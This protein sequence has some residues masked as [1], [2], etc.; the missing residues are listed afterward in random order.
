MKGLNNIY[1]DVFALQ[2]EILI[3]PHHSIHWDI[4][5]SWFF[6]P[7]FPPPSFHLQRKQRFPRVATCS[8]VAHRCVMKFHWG[9]DILITSSPHNWLLC[10]VFPMNRPSYIIRLREL[11]LFQWPV[12][13]IDT[14]QRCSCITYFTLKFSSHI[15]ASL[16]SLAK[17]ATL[18]T[19]WPRVS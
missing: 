16:F 6:L 18:S 3:S 19:L 11:R 8:L 13:F 10:Y 2:K 15:S 12:E 5:F 1:V 17:K 4:L 14:Q 7:Q 9:Q